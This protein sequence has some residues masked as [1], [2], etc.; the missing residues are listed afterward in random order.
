MPSIPKQLK[1]FNQKMC[2]KKYIKQQTKTK[3]DKV[4]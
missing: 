2:K 1:D 4:D 3:R